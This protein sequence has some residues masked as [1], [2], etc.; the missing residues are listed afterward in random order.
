MHANMQTAA[1][2]LTVVDRDDS[3]ADSAANSPRHTLF[4]FWGFLTY[5]YQMYG[6]SAAPFEAATTGST[7]KF[8]ILP[9]SVLWVRVEKLLC[10]P[11]VV[12]GS[13]DQ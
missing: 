12:F 10:W 4:L 9:P 5:N 2:S 11:P 1:A 6:A 8:A 13:S 3:A 7:S